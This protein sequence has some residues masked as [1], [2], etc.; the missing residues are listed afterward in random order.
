[1]YLIEL[2]RYFVGMSSSFKIVSC[3]CFLLSWLTVRPQKVYTFLRNVDEKYNP[4][5]G[6]P[7]LSSSLCCMTDFIPSGAETDHSHI[8]IPGGNEEKLQ[9]IG[10]DHHEVGYC[11]HNKNEG[12]DGSGMC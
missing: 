7:M 10:H 5:D 11:Q 6:I 3:L 2:Q 8:W 4:E 12:Y 9:D 1:M